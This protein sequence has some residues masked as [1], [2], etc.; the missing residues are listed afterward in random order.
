[1]NTVLQFILDLFRNE[2]AA[3]AFVANPNAALADAGLADVTPQQ[4]QSVAATAVPGCEE[5]CDGAYRR[6]LRLPA[7][8][9]IVALRPMVDEGLVEIDDDGI[10]VTANGWF[11][12]RAV[13]L[14]FDRYLRADQNRE[15]FSRIV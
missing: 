8:V 6:T 7:G 1:M 10:S 13:A 4:L 14:T 2:N 12:V 11:F 15:R 5:V 3:Q 9:G